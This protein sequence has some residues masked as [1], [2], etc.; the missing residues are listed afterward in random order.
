M[1]KSKGW[2]GESRR[3]A[4]A[5]KG[6]KTKVSKK[7]LQQH[8]TLAQK[9]AKRI[10]DITMETIKT[11]I[12]KQKRASIPDFGTFRLKRTS[13]KPRRKVRNPFTGE[14]VWAKPKKAGFKIKF[15]KAR[16]F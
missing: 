4:K 15:R 14:T 1:K 7:I 13:A 6:I 11:D 3:H 5:A 16:G 8:P 12:K 10:F 2:R 9:E